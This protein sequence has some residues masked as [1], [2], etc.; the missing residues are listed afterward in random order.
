F[1]GTASYAAPEQFRGKE[2]IDPRSDLYSLGAM[3]YELATGEVPFRAQALGDLVRKVL[4]DAP[5]RPGSLAPQLSPFFEEMLLVLLAKFPSG[6]FA[7]ARELGE[8]LD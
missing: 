3:L 8:A 2:E 1:V 4:H 5:R 6:R 7:S